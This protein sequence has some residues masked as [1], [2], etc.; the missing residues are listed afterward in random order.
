MDIFR[1]SAW[2]GLVIIWLVLLLL[3][4]FPLRKKCPALILVVLLVVKILLATALAYAVIAT[5][6]IFSY[7]LGFLLSALYVA[8]FVDAA[9]DMVL[10][11]Y[12]VQKK[13][14][15]V[16]LQAVACTL[17]TLVYFLYG[18]INMQTV[19]ANRITILSE[20]LSHEYTIAF[21]SDMHVGS[22]QS[23]NTTERTVYKIASESPDLI[24]LGGDIVD[25][26]TTKEE[27][28][29]VFSLF[30]DLNI[31]VY[32]IYG[33]HDRQPCAGMAG[34]NAFT[35]QELESTILKNN[36]QILKDEWI[37]IGDDLVILG[38]EDSSSSE[39]IPIDIISPRPEN[40]F[41][42][43]ID[44]SPYIY[45]EIEKS[46]ADLQISGHTHAAQLFPLRFIYEIAGYN[47]YGFYRH[48]NTDV[49]V[50]SGASG[51]RVPFRTEA[52]CHY[53]VITLKAP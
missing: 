1:Y 11:I 3:V 51:W 6:T 21:V 30:G 4:Q 26:Y 40:A 28:E 9:G 20:K 14:R 27:M 38:R 2:A 8:V 19:T 53:E 35:P 44:H 13:E 22:S 41:V 47:A 45:D 25:E 49:Y 24:I 42:L 15:I 12:S 37:S 31:P 23:V 18:T 10:L 50:S 36:I 52:F 43:Q 29:S 33:N 16:K 39:R 5:D 7:T 48:G 46:N 32:F 17:C 34:G